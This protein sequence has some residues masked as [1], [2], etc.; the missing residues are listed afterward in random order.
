MSAPETQMDIAWLPDNATA[1][2]CSLLLNSSS[3]PLTS[4]ATTRHKEDPLIAHPKALITAHVSSLTATTYRNMCVSTVSN[5]LA[6][7]RGQAPQPGC[8]F[9]LK[10]L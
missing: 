7:L 2:T 3:F 10:N 1:R 5:V 9:N 6:I 8:V 4:P